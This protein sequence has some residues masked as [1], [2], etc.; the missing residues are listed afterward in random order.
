MPV[1]YCEMEHVTEFLGPYL[2]GEL[3]TSQV[4]KIENHLGT[5]DQCRSE[6]ADLDNLSGLLQFSAPLPQMKSEDQF[7][8][9]VGLLLERHPEPTG[10]K[11]VLVKVLK[12]IP[13]S[14]AGTW[15]FVQTSLIITT[16]IYNVSRIAPELPGIDRLSPTLEPSIGSSALGSISQPLIAQV[17]EIITQLLNLDIQL[18]WRIPVFSILLFIIG[19]LYVCWLASWWV[20]REHR[21]TQETT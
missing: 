20:V 10:L 17:L 13:V 14:L 2:D 15:L 6:L 7:V 3:R 11:R 9:E 18:N 4:T 21:I 5:C 1:N 8:A 16:L 12:A 19:T